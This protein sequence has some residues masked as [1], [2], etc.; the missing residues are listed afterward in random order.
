MTD[1]KDTRLRDC[2]FVLG[3]FTCREGIDMPSRCQLKA[4]ADTDTDKY[5]KERVY[6]APGR[7]RLQNI[8]G[9]P[10]SASV[11]PAILFSIFANYTNE[12]VCVCACVRKSGI[13]LL[14]PKA[15]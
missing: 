10:C 4:D 11:S 12:S 15:R 8:F 1:L 2:I 3:F 9:R 13:V 7:M 6:L 5:L 14:K